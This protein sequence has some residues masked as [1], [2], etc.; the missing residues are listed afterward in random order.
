MSVPEPFKTCPCC[1]YEWSSREELLADPGVV[2]IGYQVEFDGLERGLLFF[3]HK[4]KSCQSTITMRMG[5]FLDLYTGTIY[6]DSKAESDECPRYCLDERQLSRCD[7]LCE[8]A[9]VRETIQIIQD[10]HEAAK[11]KAGLT[12]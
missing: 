11:K 8:C 1:D 7:A 12:L 4:K 2:L 3:N 9:F 5:D 6:P 10:K